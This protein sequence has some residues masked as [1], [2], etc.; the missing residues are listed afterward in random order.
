MKIAVMNGMEGEIA[1]SA[2][3]LDG[4]FRKTFSL[5]THAYCL[6]GEPGGVDNGKLYSG[7]F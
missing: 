6:S 3:R 5:N 4:N 7:A 2:C 1:L